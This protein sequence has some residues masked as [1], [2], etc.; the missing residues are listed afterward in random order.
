MAGQ[1]FLIRNSDEILHSIRSRAKLNP[2]FN[3]TQARKGMEATKIYSVPELKI[4]LQ[5]ELHPWML[6]W[7]HVVDNPFHAVS[8]LDGNYAIQGLPEG[9]YEIEAIHEKYGRQSATVKV[10]REPSVQDFTFG[11]RR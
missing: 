3:Q 11:A 5:C 4:R 8:T 10:G 9:E 6:A 2:E 1:P 7:L